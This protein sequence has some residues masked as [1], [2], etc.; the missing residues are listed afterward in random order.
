MEKQ[1]GPHSPETA[2]SADSAAQPRR[3]NGTNLQPDGLAATRDRRRQA[4][5]Y[6]EG[7]PGLLR[8]ISVPPA[9]TR[10]MTRSLTDHTSE[11][12]LL[13]PLV[14]GEALPWGG[15]SG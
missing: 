3:S 14:Q 12:R 11:C 9:T 5:L 1:L 8:N 2:S 13:C 15:T 6:T 4:L 7:A 10:A